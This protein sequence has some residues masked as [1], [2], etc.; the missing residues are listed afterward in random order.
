MIVITVAFSPPK[1]LIKCYEIITV[2]AF[3]IQLMQKRTYIYL[4]SSFLHIFFV[5]FILFSSV[6]VELKGLE[7]KGTFDLEKFQK[8]AKFHQALLFPAFNMQSIMMKRVLGAGFWWKQTKRRAQLS[9][10]EYL[11]MESFIIHVS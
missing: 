11:P 6:S 8:F 9:G 3:S 1:K 7:A 5:L 4:F 2:K 10:G